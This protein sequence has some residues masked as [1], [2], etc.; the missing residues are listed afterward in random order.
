[1]TQPPFHVS[2]VRA[3]NCQECGRSVEAKPHGVKVR[4]V[5]ERTLGTVVLCRECFARAIAV[6]D[7]GGSVTP[8]AKTP[9]TRECRWAVPGSAACGL[10]ATVVA[11]ATRKDGS[12]VADQALCEEHF[13]AFKLWWHDYAITIQRLSAP[14][15]SA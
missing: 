2:A 3:G 4:L 12:A 11:R 1:M 7:R 9:I 10:V 6:A 5:G 15:E 14:H 13:S 8:E